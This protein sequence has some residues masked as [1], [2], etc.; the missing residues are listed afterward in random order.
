MLISLLC[1]DDVIGPAPSKLPL[2][3]IPSHGGQ[4]LDPPSK[5]NSFSLRLLLSDYILISS[6]K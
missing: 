4:Y 5:A 1:T 2:I 3:G 6:G